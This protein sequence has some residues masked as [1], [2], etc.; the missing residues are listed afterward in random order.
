MDRWKGVDSMISRI[1]AL[2]TYQQTN[3]QNKQTKPYLVTLPLI[4]GA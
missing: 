4:L 1:L 2:K 3:K